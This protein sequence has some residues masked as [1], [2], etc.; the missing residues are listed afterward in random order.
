MNYEQVN[1]VQHLALAN[2]EVLGRLE[3]EC[4]ECKGKG[5]IF[6]YIDYSRC[7]NCKGKKK[8][9]YK[10]QPK[11]GEWVLLNLLHGANNPELIYRI[12]PSPWVDVTN[13]ESRFNYKRLTPILPWEVC[14]EILAKAGFSAQIEYTTGHKSFC[15]IK[16][17]GLVCADF[18]SDPT[19][20]TYK[21]ILR[22]GKELK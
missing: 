17:P 6:P 12:R 14:F 10:W 2:Y 22:L 8:I 21:T 1:N 3:F 19:E 11:V 18:G 7:K 5:L 13:H 15:T 4:P 20:A 9:K 16:R